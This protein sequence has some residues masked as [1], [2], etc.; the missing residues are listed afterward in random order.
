VFDVLFRLLRHLYGADHVTYV[1]NITDVDD[2]INA[3]AAERNITIQKLTDETYR[4]FKDD[5]AAL[6]CLDPTHEPRAT[7]YIRRPDS[8]VDMVTLIERL[9]RSENA[10][11]AEDHVLFHVPSMPDYGKLSRRSLDEMIAGARVEVAP[12]KRNPM[13]FVLW[14]PSDQQKSNL[15]LP[16]WR[17]PCGINMPGRPGWHIEC[18]AMSGSILGETFDIHGGGIDLLFPHHENEIAQSRCAFH[19]PVMAN[20]WMHNGFLQVEGEKM[21]KSEGNFVT[22]RDVLHSWNGRT[23]PGAA[24]R[25][26]MLQTH[27][28]EPIDWSLTHLSQSADEI[29]RFLNLLRGYHRNSSGKVDI[30]RI[31]SAIDA[32]RPSDAVVAA[33]CDDLNTSRAITA[34][35]AARMKRTREL[36]VQVARD[37]I[38][39]GV[40]K[41]S[42][43]LYYS[44]FHG[45]ESDVA[46]K[47]IVTS[48]ATDYQMARANGDLTFAGALVTKLKDRGLRIIENE[49]SSITISTGFEEQ[50]FDE[51]V[52]AQIALRSAARARKDWKEADRI[53]DELLAM[54]VR[55]KDNPDGTSTPE[56]AR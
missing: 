47:N 6:G 52:R 53:R 20:F 41:Q 54:G 19:T 23:W 46:E 25:W 44:T 49:T 2:K 18:S 43:I 7:Q 14:K 13:D 4:D 11:C 48:I 12:Y 26:A 21:A 29:L 50:S 38:F 55:L 3:R 35:R 8:K 16:A 37:L 27:Y 40:L 9:V 24:V 10:Y 51:T 32:A 1:R 34:I 15:E 45:V 17:S 30:E 28:R 31:A 36:A 39:L 56:I 42:D 5:V 22:I 33:L